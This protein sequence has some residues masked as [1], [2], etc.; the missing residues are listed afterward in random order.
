MVARL[1][2][3]Q[4]RVRLSPA[5]AFEGRR[6]IRT[7]GP[8]VACRRA[9]P[10]RRLSGLPTARAAALELEGTPNPRRCRLTISHHG[11]GRMLTNGTERSR[12]LGASRPVHCVGCSNHIQ[13]ANGSNFPWM[14]GGGRSPDVHQA[15]V[16]A[17][18]PSARRAA[19]SG[20]GPNG[21]VSGVT[22][23]PVVNVNGKLPPLGKVS[24]TK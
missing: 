9:T 18:C 4:R 13:S 8:G 15:K 12:D 19:I 7:L 16:S 2:A 22:R 21:R 14:K 20:G 1:M 10:Y 23:T 6:W 24:S 5:S 11:L 3:L 17:Q